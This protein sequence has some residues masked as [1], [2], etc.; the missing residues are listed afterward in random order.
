MGETKE[1]V[2]RKEG[3][4]SGAIPYRKPSKITRGKCLFPILGKAPP[5]RP[6]SPRDAVPYPEYLKTCVNHDGAL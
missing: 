4:Q 5:R 3:E 1:K 2:I 6:A